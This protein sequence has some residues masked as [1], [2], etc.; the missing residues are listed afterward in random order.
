MNIA[1]AILLSGFWITFSEFLRNEILFKSYW[2][3]HFN[4]IGLKFETL[5][6]NGM[7]WTL[8]SFLLAFVIFILLQKFSFCKTLFLTWILAF[9]MMWIVAYNLQVL[10]T[11]ILLI[12]IPLS[13]LEV[14][15]AIWIIRKLL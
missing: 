9:V 12:S 3:N 5:P 6:L 15:V 1:I 13:L 11:S 14:F 8:W 4:S 2:V 7:L 10:P